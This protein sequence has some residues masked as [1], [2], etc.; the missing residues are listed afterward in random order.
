MA[1]A[2]HPV[3]VG[4]AGHIDHGKSSLVKALTGIDPDRLAEEQRRGLTIDLG[5][6]RLKLA[7]GR[8]MGL[9][10]VP[11]HE[12][13]VRNMVAGCTGLDLVMLVVAADDG[14]MPQ[15]R[16][17]LDII[18]L[19]GVRSGLIV[20]SKIDM[21][22]PVLA[23]LAED[24]VRK[25][26]QGTVLADA[27]LLRISSL[28]GEGLPELRQALEAMALQIPPRTASGPFRMPIQR[29]F[30]LPGIGTV[31]TGIPVSGEIEPGTL[32][33]ALPGGQQFE[34]R[35]L[36]AYGGKV[37][38]AVAGHSTA[39][40]VPAA[41]QAGL[42][43]GMVVVQPGLFH[44]GDALDV[45]LELTARS[46]RLVHRTP[47]R[48]HTGTVEVRGSL[49]LLAVDG[50]GPT[51]QATARL[52]LDEAIC[53]A[54]HDRFLL[55]L[56]NPPITVGGGRVLRLLETGRLRRA[57]LAAELQAMVQAGDRPEARLR[58]ELERVGPEG[59]GID[60]LARASEQTD[61]EVLA[62]LA[63]MPDIELDRIAMRAFVATAVRAGEAEL[64]QAV[65]R[66]LARRP[67]A[68]SIPRLSLRTS[69]T[70]PAALLEHVLARM[71]ASGR[72]RPVRRGQILFVARLR[73][74]D[75]QQQ[76]RLQQLVSFCRE[77][78]QRPPTQA[79]LAAALGCS[80]D[81]LQGLL[82]RAQDEGLVEAVG[83]HI[84]AASVVRAVLHSIRGN[85]LRNQE[86]LDIP[87]LRDELN[88]SRKYLI[89]LLEHVDALG[90]TVLRGGVRR[91]LP[92]STIH[93]QL[94]DEAG[95]VGAQG[96]A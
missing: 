67:E 28:T 1:R 26:V 70:L 12:R 76:Q 6:A 53:C 32:V 30:S 48:C 85:C 38:R 5:F 25:L 96:P 95:A 29:V 34:V 50:L 78:G 90:L 33:E 40:A 93:R 56:Q 4:T 79:E 8:W 18:H 73:P 68:A 59:C 65:E 69:K 36:H 10:D 2:I 17:H 86:I 21:V 9:V 62:L 57:E 91:L 55:R 71:Q 39:L 74:L 66:I 37:E 11:G 94:A 7:D 14:V 72:V 51:E 20:L 27:P 19:L 64:E 58:L 35:G 60:D 82:D 80:G 24:E 84:Y 23:D 61:S 89:P 77:A 31:V 13:F 22:D 43:R 49:V 92:S 54:Q 87:S 63:G 16:E 52:E 44:S 3:V 88:T 15:T 45:E 41:R 42:R 75:P 83:E 46:P 81:A 47:I